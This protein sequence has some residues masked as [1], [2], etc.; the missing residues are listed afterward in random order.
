MLLS[1]R[2]GQPVDL[3]QDRAGYDALAAKSTV[4]AKQNEQDQWVRLDL[5]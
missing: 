4:L 3:P 2:K 5:K 1:G